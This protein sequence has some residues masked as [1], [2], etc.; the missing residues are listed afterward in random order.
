MATEPKGYRV[1]PRRAAEL[2]SQIDTL[3]H[4][5]EQAEAAVRRLERRAELGFALARGRVA[6]ELQVLKD[7]ER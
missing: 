4:R 2:Q 5:L 3:A 1:T 7:A 6:A